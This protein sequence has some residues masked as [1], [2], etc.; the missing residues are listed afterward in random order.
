MTTISPNR[1]GDA[2]GEK[3]DGARSRF[4]AAEFDLVPDT[5]CDIA[6]ACLRCPLP[7]C[8]FDDPAAAR[9]WRRGP[10]NRQI[11]ARFEAGEPPEA[12]AHFFGISRRS[13]YRALAEARRPA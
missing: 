10:R 7:S 9:R 4:P 12:L 3:I 1:N 8:K 2:C 5:G 11:A 6:P 13:V